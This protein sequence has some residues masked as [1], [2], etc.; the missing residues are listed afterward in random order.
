MK[1]KVL[2][3][4]GAGFIGSN[5]VDALIAGGDSVAVVDNLSTGRLENLN[6]KA[7]FYK[8]DIRDAAVAGIFESER[9]DVVCHHAAQVNVRTSV[10]DPV[11]DADINVLGSINL[12][13]CAVKHGVKKFVFASSG[14]AVYGEQ[15]VFPATESHPTRPLS[16]YGI[17]KRT[18][19]HYLAYYRNVHGL[20][21]TAL[22]YANVY[23]PRQD[24]YG[25]A[26]V[27]AIF[28]AKMLKG[29]TPTVN[30]DGNQTRDY[31]YVGDVV[32]ANLLALKGGYTG[33][34]NVGTGVEVSVNEL[35]GLLKER[36]G[37]TGDKV[38]GPAKAGEQLRSVIDHGLIKREMGWTPEVALGDGLGFTV[39]Y[40]RKKA[41]RPA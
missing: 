26:G 12:L 14:G 40:F 7:V 38:H 5:I 6:P 27:V 3:T 22:R 15:E 2:V 21:Y 25:E 4:G 10:D 16:P 9:P 30:G 31:V 39:E 18:I 29:E 11:L 17:T 8:A 1:M 41:G 32:R 24:P 28:T 33:Y 20:E 37:Y 34:F 35:Y 19:E 13:Q 36:T 23:G